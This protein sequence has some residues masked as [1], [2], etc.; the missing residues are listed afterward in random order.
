MR[1]IGV[2]EQGISDGLHIGAQIYVSRGGEVV[3]DAALGDARA[4]VPMTTETLMNW[5][6]MTKAITAIAVAQQWEAGRLDL[7]APAATYLPEFGANRKDAITLR[8]LLTHTAGIPNADG[9]FQG[10]PWRESNA[11]SLARI[12]AA[13]PEYLPGTRAG[14]H[15]GAGMTVLGEIV[16][17]V[18]GRPYEQYVRERIFAPV[19]ADNCWVGMPLEEYERYGDRIGFM[20]DTTGDAAR[21]LPRINSA[22]SAATPMPGGGGRG[23]MRELAQVYEALVAGGGPLLTPTTVAAFAARHRTEMIDETFGIVV[24]WGLGFTIDSAA[25]GSH[26]SRRAFGHGGHL[27]SVAFC[28]PAH[29]VVV[30]VVCNGM[31]ARDAHYARLDAVSSAAYVDLGLAEPGARGRVKE[32]PTVGL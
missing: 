16:A 25:M 5:F 15:A 4:G 23:P 13:A 2:L 8:H 22:R 28:D 20:H 9:M 21:P 24:D 19:G 12:Y 18:S 14:Y 26:C 7:D 29:E 27:S 1:V 30:A 3:V 11:E 6:S 10:E 31:P 17:R 32:Y